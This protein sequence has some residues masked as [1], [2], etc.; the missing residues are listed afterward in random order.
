MSGS[1]QAADKE[2]VAAIMQAKQAA[3]KPDMLRVALGTLQADVV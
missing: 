3:G 2:K 1:Q